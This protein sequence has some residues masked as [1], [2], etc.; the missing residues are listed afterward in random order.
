MFTATDYITEA[1]HETFPTNE[2]KL[3]KLRKAAKLRKEEEEKL[4]KWQEEHPEDESAIPDWKKGAIQI[5]E[6]KKTWKQKVKAKI[7]GSTFG[8][9]VTESTHTIL[10]QDNVIKAKE[11]LTD[12]KEGIENL[13]LDLKDSIQSSD[14]KIIQAGKEIL[15]KTFYE[16]TEARATR[17]IRAYD[18]NFDILQLEND[19]ENIVWEFFQHCLDKDIE[20][21]TPIVDGS[22]AEKIV[23]QLRSEDFDKYRYVVTEVARPVFLGVNIEDKTNPKFSF[24]TTIRYRGVKIIQNDNKTVKSKVAKGKDKSAFFLK[25]FEMVIARHP[26]P[27]YDTHGHPWQFIVFQDLKDQKILS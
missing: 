9:K 27:N 1:L 18:A 22:A 5:V 8:N 14:S 26:D 17:A 6:E 12:L 7:L 15:E 24:H 20:Y 16:T 23:N 13:T 25:K 2:Y 10:K 19:L 11:N 4:K 3:K 21:I